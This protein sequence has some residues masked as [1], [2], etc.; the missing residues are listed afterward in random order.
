MKTLVE[1]LM[2]ASIGEIITA[3]LIAAFIIRLVYEII[4]DKK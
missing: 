1:Y 3:I 2:N 4:A